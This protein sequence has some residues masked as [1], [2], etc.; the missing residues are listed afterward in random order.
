[1]PAWCGRSRRLVVITGLVIYLVATLSLLL[2][3]PPNIDGW[4]TWV[5]GIPWAGRLPSASA[6]PAGPGGDGGAG[7][8]PASGLDDLSE[9]AGRKKPTTTDAPVDAAAAAGPGSSELLSVLV[10]DRT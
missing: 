5:D 10:P 1:M 2:L 9:R 4:D 6:V 8:K 3:Y 7:G